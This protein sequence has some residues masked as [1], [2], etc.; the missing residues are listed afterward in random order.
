M[1]VYGSK[2]QFEVDYHPEK[3]ITMIKLPELEEFFATA[4][5]PTTP[6]RISACETV[7]D[8]KKFVQSH[9]SILK[10]NPGKAVF[11]PYYMRLLAFKNA[12]S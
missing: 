12:I 7:I 9:I 4:I 2:K 11:L 10:N 6:V 1:K 5:L 8:A 3:E